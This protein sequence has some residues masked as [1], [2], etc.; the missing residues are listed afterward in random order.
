MPLK[1][2]AISTSPRAGGN[3]DTLLG[4]A[5]A[6]AAAA[7]A[8]TEYV[9]LA[10]LTIG[11]CS[12]CYACARTGICR[13]RDDFQ[14]VFDRLLAADRLIFATP[15]FFMAV[16][17]QGKLAIDRCQCLWSRKYLLRE[18][19]FPPG[20]RDRRAMVIAA[21]GSKSRKMFEC[22]RLTMKYWL[23][24]LEMTPAFELFVNQVDEKGAVLR[25]PR[26][27]AEARRL[28]A[29]LADPSSPVPA[30]P[31]TVE[32]YEPPASPAEARRP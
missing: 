5:L 24:A 32:I 11:P 7:G 29:A 2:L 28:G 6:G 8:E 17:A 9:S 26:A 15:V 23:D 4:S 13:I 31:E 1:V 25:S 20:S 18:P 10:D 12:A 14:G 21:G 16:C 22:I 27:V 30:R 19:L 3:S